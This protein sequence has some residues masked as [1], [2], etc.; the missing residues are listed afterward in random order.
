MFYATSSA[1]QPEGRQA[2][3][4]TH[5]T[6]YEEAGGLAL[7]QWLPGIKSD[8]DRLGKQRGPGVSPALFW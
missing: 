5:R 6:D 1:C 3:C 2:K 4:V 8:S 7:V